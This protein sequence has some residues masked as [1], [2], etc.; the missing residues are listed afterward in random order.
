MDD[1]KQQIREHIINEIPNTIQNF[2]QTVDSTPI[3]ILDDTPNIV[4]DSQDYLGPI[5]EFVSTVE[6][7]L[8]RLRPDS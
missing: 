3:R 6:D 5:R 2:L 4:L 1:N 8:R 7:R